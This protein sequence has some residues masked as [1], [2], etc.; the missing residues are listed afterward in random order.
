MGLPLPHIFV[1]VVIDA[2]NNRIPFSIGAVNYAAT[3]AVGTYLTITS[4]LDAA[5][6]AMNAAAAG[7]AF[8]ATCSA[9]GR[10]TIASASAF[11]LKFATGATSP[12]SPRHLLGFGVYDTPA[13]LSTTSPYQHQYGWYGDRPV[14]RDPKPSYEQVVA[15]TRSLTGRVRTLLYGERETR[16]LRFGWMPS[17][18]TKTYFEPAALSYDGANHQNEALERVWRLATSAGR[19]RYWPDQANAALYVD[20][21]LSAESASTFDPSRHAGPAL[22]QVEW[23]LFRYVE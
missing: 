16:K 20:F 15:V 14:A 3:I 18:K 5:A 6:A 13:G 21:C 2:T 7:A 10:I 8:V 19:F 23:N 11:A 12:S 4:L 22:F 9:T 17:H 1:P